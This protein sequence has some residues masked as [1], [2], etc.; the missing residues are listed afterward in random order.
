MRSVQVSVVR[1][2]RM[3]RLRRRGLETGSRSTLHGHEGGNSGYSQGKDLRGASHVVERSMCSRAPWLHGSCPASQ[4]LRAQPPPSRL[5]PISR[6]HR[7]YDLPCSVDFST[8]RGRLLQLLSVSLLPCCP[9]HPAGVDC[10]VVQAATA[11]AAFVRQ[12]RTRPPDMGYRG[13][14]WVHLRYGPATR[15]PS[16][17]WLCRWASDHLVSLLPAIQATGP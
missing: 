10:R 4:L 17:R 1:E 5:R 13:Y 6:G 11:H 2:I 16:S 14:L 9:Y 7:L 12:Q 3:L 8:G 15:S